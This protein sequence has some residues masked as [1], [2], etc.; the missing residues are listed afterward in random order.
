[1]IQIV[2]VLKRRAF[3]GQSRFGPIT[4]G[5]DENLRAL[6]GHARVETLILDDSYHMV[7]LDQQRHLVLDRTERFVSWLEGRVA[8]NAGIDSVAKGRAVE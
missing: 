7:T 1:M 8:A 6:S 3:D 5:G 2:D 4:G